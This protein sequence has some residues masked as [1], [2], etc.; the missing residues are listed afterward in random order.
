MKKPLLLLSAAL[1]VSVAATSARTIQINQ[2]QL[3]A[4]LSAAHV[5]QTLQGLNQSAMQNAGQ[6]KTTASERVATISKYDFTLPSGSQVVDSIRLK[7][8]NGR[9]SAFDY[10]NL[11]YDFYNHASHPN[12]FIFENNYLQFD[13]ARDARSG[14][15]TASQGY[16]AAGNVLQYSDDSM[17]LQYTY[18]ASN[19]LSRITQYKYNAT[20]GA[21][22]ANYRNLY[23]YNTDGFLSLDSVE[24]WDVSSASWQHQEKLKY[25][26]DASGRVS[27]LSVEYDLPNGSVYVIAHQRVSYPGS[28]TQPASVVTEL[29]NG[30]GLD[31]NYRENFAYS[32]AAMTFHEAYQ[33]TG[34][35]D[36]VSQEYRHLNAANLPDS[37]FYRYWN[38]GIAVDSTYSLLA[39]NGQNN[40]LYRLDYSRTSTLP[41]GGAAW[42]YESTAP[43]N[44]NHLN[45][46]RLEFYPNPASDNITLK[47][48]TGGD[49]QVF[50]TAG[51]LVL[52][53]KMPNN[54]SISVQ[55]LTPG[56]Y[57]LHVQDSYGKQLQATFIRQ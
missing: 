45:V 20:V 7:Y 57:L 2:N 34:G 15:L 11:D 3:P 43:T 6:K 33:W 14:T 50:N 54:P 32:N 30:H 23:F 41:Y 40:P 53:G 5:N 27:F 49:Y 21:L 46:A 22:E 36:L 42:T 56:M 44:V 12:P 10:S 19:R 26:Y 38:A 31:S 51:A 8:A 55:G 9:G 16:N 35:W 29:T 24:F 52:S 48:V 39:Y 13:T 25:S 37:V 18:D 1:F 4:G 17:L 47:A 28:L